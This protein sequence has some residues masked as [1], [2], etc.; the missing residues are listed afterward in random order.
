[1]LGK[2]V[3]SLFGGS[4]DLVRVHT[5]LGKERADNL[6]FRMQERHQKVHRLQTR[7]PSLLSQGLRLLHSLL[8]LERE[9]LESECHEIASRYGLLLLLEFDVED[10]FGLGSVT[11]SA[12]RR[13][14][15]ARR[16]AFT[17]A[18]LSLPARIEMF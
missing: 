14:A 18:S 6:L 13:T 17:A 10:V 5:K 12:G 2:D 15:R 9:L 16:R 8:A 11:I 1:G 7:V 4:P 3:Q